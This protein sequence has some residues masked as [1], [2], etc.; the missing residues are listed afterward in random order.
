M[1]K[2][3]KKLANTSL[4]KVLPERLQWELMSLPFVPYNGPD[5]PKQELLSE[6]NQIAQ[7]IEDKINSNHEI[8][9]GRSRI[10]EI[11]AGV[12]RVAVPVAKRGGEVHVTD[13]SYGLLAKCKKFAKEE[14]VQINTHQ[15]SSSLEISGE[16][17]VVYSVNV[18]QHIRRRN[19]VQYLIESHSILRD[20]GVLY[21]R[22][23]CLRNEENR[24]TLLSSLDDTT[25]FRM[26]YFV[27]E[28]LRQFLELAEFKPI[29]IER[30]GTGI[31]V[32]AK[33]K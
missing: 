7:R 9:F 23:P 4:S 25:S 31:D 10:L 18:F 20:N 2:N 32:L 19:T 14:G 15:S 6:G 29:F 12:G 3:I 26:R 33:P 16:F 1:E 27:K 13:I 28:E 30:N 17:D 11:G 21:F 8:K 22:V 5:R 24:Q